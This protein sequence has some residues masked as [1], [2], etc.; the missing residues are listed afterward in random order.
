MILFR[1]PLVQP[2][3]G[4][5]HRDYERAVLVFADFDQ[6]GHRLRLHGAQAR[7][8]CFVLRGFPT[9]QQV[10]RHLAAGVRLPRA[11]TPHAVPW[12][13]FDQI[14]FLGEIHVPL[15]LLFIMLPSAPGVQYSWLW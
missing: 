1:Q 5:R 15:R 12:Q 4:R 6:L 13:Q 2:L 10:H 9:H 14:I 11:I 8:K 7:Q 3:V